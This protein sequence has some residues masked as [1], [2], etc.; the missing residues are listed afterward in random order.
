MFTWPL[1]VFKA[2]YR[3]IEAVNGMDAYFFVRFLRM[4]MIIFFPIWLIS[5]AVL[6]PVTS[7]HTKVS[8]YS[9]LDMFVLGN[10]ETTKQTRFAAHI[11]LAW[12]FTCEYPLI[13]LS[14]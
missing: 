7:V 3:D 12:F 13:P 14:S 2:D 1:A 5:W 10:V 6:L 11:I 4:M 8:G 9:G